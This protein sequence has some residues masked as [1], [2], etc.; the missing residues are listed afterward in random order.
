MIR[1][2]KDDQ[3][4]FLAICNIHDSDDY[5]ISSMPD[6]YYQ[7]YLCA[8]QNE[9]KIIL[10]ICSMLNK[11]LHIDSSYH[12]ST[13]KYGKPYI[14]HLGYDFNISHSDDFV[15]LAFS[16]N[17]VGVDIEN[18]HYISTNTLKR[19]LHKNDFD[20]LQRQKNDKNYS[21]IKGYYWTKV[22]A[23][24]KAQGTGFYVDP[25]ENDFYDKGWYT[26]GFVFHQGYIVTCASQY[27]FVI[28]RL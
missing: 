5:F 25:R 9:K 7:K 12:I 24:L 4:V 14:D 19:V 18:V 27:P 21:I 15:A 23:I 1:M 28:Q 22:E 2:A 10:T 17:Q 3:I 26:S 8:H 11:Y 13:N 6:Y 20:T 16:K